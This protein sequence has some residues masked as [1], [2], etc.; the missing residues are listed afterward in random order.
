MS[1]VRELQ[2]NIYSLHDGHVPQI[3]STQHEGY[4]CYRPVQVR[5]VHYKLR[6]N[7]LLHQ[8]VDNQTLFRL[9]HPTFEITT[10]KAK[11]SL[12]Q[13]AMKM[14]RRVEVL[15]HAILEFGTR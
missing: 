8:N 4:A 6:F 5:M 12:K 11:F 2:F 1:C 10:V 15:I 13:H 9:E 7:S 14:C 3:H